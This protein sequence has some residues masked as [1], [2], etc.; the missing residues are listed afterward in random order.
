MS[1]A[2]TTEETPET[3]EEAAPEEEAAP[4]DE[5]REGIAER[6]RTELGDGVVEHHVRAGDDLWVQVTLGAWREAAVVA[7]DTLGCTY[8][9]FVSAIDW[10]PSP[11]GRDMDALEDV[12][13]GN[14]EPKAAGEMTWGFAGG[15]S[16]FQMLARVYS[17]TEHYGI[18]L[19]TD[20]DDESPTVDSWVP[21][22]PG[23]DWHERETWEMYGITFTGHPG[24]RHIY[25]PGDFEGN[26][27][28]KDF[29]LL[30][31]RVKPWPGIVDVE[32]MPGEDEEEAP[33][34]ELGAEAEAAATSAEEAP[35]H[36]EVQE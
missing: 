16:R 15:A 22:Y 28:R 1:D 33:A 9:D 18:T 19:K 35:D 8:F 4:T 32:Q 6:L 30:A 5:L 17:P 10:L 3:T 31:R 13:A 29:P 12:L 20:L 21:V 7:R 36:D 34:D 2:P 24:L 26:P 25:L 23:A 14:A 11:V 27:L